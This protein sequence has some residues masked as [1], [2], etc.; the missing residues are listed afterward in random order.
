MEPV[1]LATLRNRLISCW[2][3]LAAVTDTLRRENLLVIIARLEAH[4]KEIEQATKPVRQS[5]DAD[6]G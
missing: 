2:R 1:E 6:V 4:I 3:E 5:P